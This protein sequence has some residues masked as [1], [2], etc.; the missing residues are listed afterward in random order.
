MQK[1]KR[2]GKAAVNR[3]QHIVYAMRHQHQEDQQG[4]FRS[5]LEE[6]LDGGDAY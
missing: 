4:W 6:S 5:A 3:R 2:L 1:M